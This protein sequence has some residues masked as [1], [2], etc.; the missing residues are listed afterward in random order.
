MDDKEQIEALTKRLEEAFQMVKVD[1]ALQECECEYTPELDITGDEVDNVLTWKCWSC[2]WKEWEKKAR[3]TVRGA[4]LSE[5]AAV[6][7]AEFQ[8]HVAQQLSRILV[9]LRK[10]ERG[11]DEIH[12]ACSLDLPSRSRGRAGEGNRTFKKDYARCP[13]CDRVVACYVPRGG[14]GS[15]LMLYRH[16]GIVI[17]R[18]TEGRFWQPWCNGD[19]YAIEGTKTVVALTAKEADKLLKEKGL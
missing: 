8:A 19:F 2:R 15:A 7:D 16:L 10:T 14:D 9:R 6:P 18:L 5:D 17:E 12:R 4:P 13:V 11:V 3:T 1:P